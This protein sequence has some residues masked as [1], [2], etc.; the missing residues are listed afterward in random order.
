M[1]FSL[2]TSRASVSSGVSIMLLQLVSLGGHVTWERESNAYS[3][4]IIIFL[5]YP[6]MQNLLTF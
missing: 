3:T 5:E 1:L 4:W 6:G 2:K